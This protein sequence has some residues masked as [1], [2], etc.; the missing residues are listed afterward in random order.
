MSDNTDLPTT[1]QPY[2]NPY[3]GPP[4]PRG[5]PGP[6]GIPGPQGPKGDP[7]RRGLDGTGGIPGPPGH[8]FMIPVSF[9][10]IWINRRFIKTRAFPLD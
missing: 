6:P 2:Y 5:Y 10:S 9:K 4:G 7:G 8:V 3:R 1:T